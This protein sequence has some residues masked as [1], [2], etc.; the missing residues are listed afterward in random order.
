MPSYTVARV[1]NKFHL[2]RLELVTL[3][4]VCLGSENETLDTVLPQMY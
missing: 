4:S 3:A 1:L 2:L